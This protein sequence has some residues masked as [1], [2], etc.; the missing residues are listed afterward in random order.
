MTSATRPT[1]LRGTLIL[2]MSALLTVYSVATAAP[3]HAATQLT[4]ALTQVTGSAPWNSTAGPGLDTTGS[5]NIVR[6]NDVV[7]YTVSVTASTED[8]SNVTITIPFP[9]GQQMFDPA[10]GVPPQFTDPLLK[11]QV[12]AFCASWTLTPQT[13][14]APPNPITL[15]SKNALPSQT[16]TCNVGT[17]PVGGA[18]PFTFV[19]MVRPE[20]ANGDVMTPVAATVTGTSAV[21]GGAAVSTTTGTVSQTVSATS[22]WNVGI[23]GGDPT[24]N[25]V[26]VKQGG[27]QAC[28]YRDASRATVYPDLVGV[29]CFV[30]GYPVT[31]SIPDAGKGGVPVV[32]G[33]FTFVIHTSPEATYGAA[34]AGFTSPADLQAYGGRL[35]LMN[36]CD[37]PNFQTPWPRIGLNANAKADNSVR[38]SGTVTCTQPGGPGTDI[39]VTATGVDTSAFTIP[40]YGLAPSGYELAKSLGFVFS[41]RVW[42]QW[43]AAG[44]TKFGTGDPTRA[45]I[46][47]RVDNLQETDIDGSPNLAGAEQA[48][49][50][51]RTV[52]AQYANFMAAGGFFAGVPNAPTTTPPA[53]FSPGYAS[54]TGP[55]GPA[56]INSGDGV[57]VTG[58]HVLGT[59]HLQGDVQPTDAGVTSLSCMAFDSTKSRL[60]NFAVPD[61]GPGEQWNGNTGTNGQ[62]G[63]VWI[64]GSLVNYQSISSASTPFAQRFGTIQ[65]QY[66]SGPTPVAG[67]TQTT[68]NDASGT[69]YDTPQAVPGNDAAQAANGIYTAVNRVRI[70][71]Q[72]KHPTSAVTVRTTV[73]VGLTVVDQTA[74]DLVPMWVSSTSAGG[75]QTLAQ[76]AAPTQTWRTNTYDP[77][78][79]QPANQTR[80]GDRLT[81]VQGLGH[82]DKQ[83]INPAG[84]YVSTDSWVPSSQDWTRSGM[85]APPAYTGGSRFSYRLQP[86]LTADT[87]ATFSQRFIV[88]DCLPA[89]VRFVSASLTPTLVQDG[90]TPESPITCPANQAFVEWDLGQRQINQPIPAITVNVRVLETALS[91]ERVND[92]AVAAANDPSAIAER[93]GRATIIINTPDGFKISKQTGTRIIAAAPS[94]YNSPRVGTWVI[95]AANIGT[96]QNVSN[97]DLI[98]VLPVNGR[99]GSNFTGPASFLA[100]TV[101]AGSGIE[102]WY[103]SAPSASIDGDARAATNLAGGSTVWCS[104]VSGGTPM[105]AGQAATACPTSAAG[106]TGVRMTRPG[107]YGT[108][109][110]FE[111]RL[112]F[113]TNDLSDGN[114]LIN[115]VSARADGI[116]TLVGPVQAQI[117]VVKNFPGSI[118]GVAWVDANRDGVRQPGEALLPGVTVRLMD[119]A[120][121]PIKCPTPADAWARCTA[122]TDAQGAYSFANLGE[123]AYTAVFAAPGHM[124]AT[125]PLSV[126]ATIDSITSPNPTADAGFMWNGTITGTTWMDNNG[127]KVRDAGEPPVGGVTVTLKD[128]QGSVVARTTSGPDGTYSLPN[129]P[130]GNYTVSFST[131]P[132]TA[133]T[134]AVDVPIA[135]TRDANRAVVDVGYRPGGAITGVTW[136]DKNGNGVRDDGEPPLAG[137]EVTIT[138]SSGNTVGKETT[139][140]DGSYNLTGLPVGQYTVTFTTPDG[141]TPTT[142]V[143]VSVTLT[144]DNQRFVANAGFQAPRP[145]SATTPPP[146][147][148]ADTGSPVS[149]PGLLVA[150][151]LLLAGAAVT[152][153][154]LRR[155]RRTP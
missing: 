3:A 135:L 144:L 74:G 127:N 152:I 64:S 32:D 133:P 35:D 99:N 121:N 34:A 81:V 1:A 93:S 129:L 11:P 9:A 79:N 146:G 57:A 15:T 31:I 75:M 5:D 114:T 69:W 78:A 115:A 95:N 118:S 142:P 37:V 7:S 112:D 47:A 52:N 55:S 130:D 126:P 105:Y 19:T 73:S 116:A 42:I 51:Y 104:G 4:A 22:K 48:W 140:S 66:S 17:I 25:D 90:S 49:D 125:T 134:T 108:A 24:E 53:A 138:D 80:L 148:L 10:V 30:G 137:V 29:M 50:N 43:P 60:S 27:V 40:T 84:S 155:R 100:A 149:L 39:I 23:N 117:D 109:D 38:N 110:T 85:S 106:V 46:T 71:I 70:L 28:E 14:V 76:M 41:Q 33:K 92:A 13:I 26:F 16:L 151:G 88:Y 124:D 120:G 54:W 150:L 107:A 119:D 147:G 44:I 123:G 20:M 86:T 83:V 96:A 136:D 77:A 62:T 103:T 101:V 21:T 36:R 97:L 89:D 63:P 61:G 18:R 122:V 58:Q 67:A 87:T 131:P 56:G 94:G 8:A 145:A 6:T 102:L 153:A 2:I 111:V 139:G 128:G 68:C 72:H 65:I 98:D 154:G 45:P 143:T 91:G 59:I 12:P 132:G 113:S 82:V 141:R